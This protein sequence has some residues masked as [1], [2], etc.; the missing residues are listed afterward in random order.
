MALL[1]VATVI[2]RVPQASSADPTILSDVISEA[3]SLADGACGRTL[4]T[5]AYTEYHD[6]GSEQETVCLRQSP[7][8]GTPVVY[9]DANTTAPTTLVAD[10]DYVLDTTAGILT[11]LG[12]SFPSGPRNLK[13]TY[14]A[15]YTSVTLPAGLRRVLL[16]VVGWIL[17]SAGNSGATSEAQDGYN[18]NYETI[19]AGLP[20]SLWNALQPWRKVVLG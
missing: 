2:S 6:I 7:I 10:T 4:E 20:D 8:T 17:E 3:Q 16:Q 13:V 12:D 18:V 15:G 1:T 19:R 14:T 11:T 5:T 9:S